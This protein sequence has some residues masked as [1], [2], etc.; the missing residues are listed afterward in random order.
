MTH[1]NIGDKAPDFSKYISKKELKGKKLVLYFYPK[2]N[3]PGCTTQACNLRDNYEDLTKKGFV[4]LGVSPDSEASHE[5]FTEKHN[6]PFKLIAD[7]EKELINAFG[8][9]GEK[10]NYGKVYQGLHRTTF[11]ID[12]NGVIENIFKKPQ[13]KVHTEQIFKKYEF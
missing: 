10:K 4:I 9:W 11:I 5:K 7:T 1:L 12:E 13:T 8:V 6:L 3:T 2:D